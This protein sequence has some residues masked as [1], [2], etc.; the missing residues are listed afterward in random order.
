SILVQ[1]ADAAEQLHAG[2]TSSGD[3]APHLSLLG[4][5]A[6]HQ[7]SRVQPLAAYLAVGLEQVGQALAWLEA[8]DVEDVRCA[9]APASEGHH[10]IE[11]AQVDAV[12]ND[13]VV[14]GEV[15][16]DEVPSGG[17][18]CDASMQPAGEALEHPLAELVGGAPAGV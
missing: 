12:G 3:V 6:D 9:V 2:Q 5:G 11:G 8:A 18:D 13:L 4:T 7:Q 10:V 15:A 17:A 16:L 1:L 14:A